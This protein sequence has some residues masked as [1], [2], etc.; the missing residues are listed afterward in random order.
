MQLQLQ[1]HYI[2]LH[3]A[4][5]TLQHTTTTTTLHFTTLHYT[6]YTT[7]QLHSNDPWVQLGSRIALH[8]ARESGSNEFLQ[9]SP[10]AIKSLRS[11]DL[12]KMTRNGAQ[13]FSV[14]L[15]LVDDL[16]SEKLAFPELRWRAICVQ[17]FCTNLTY[18][19]DLTKMLTRFENVLAR[20]ENEKSAMV[21]M[22][23]S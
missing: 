4:T 6:N 15:V 13:S 11:R 18:W 21:S 12:G 7:L 9:T 19:Q 20:F 3:Y 8:L 17:H 16:A 5:I 14:D 23:A 10:M 2:T 1:L 22:Q